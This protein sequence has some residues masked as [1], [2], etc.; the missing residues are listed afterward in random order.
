MGIDAPEV[1]GDEAGGDDGG[2]VGRDAISGED[3]CD[4][5]FGGRGGHVVLCL[6]GVGGIHSC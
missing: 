2:V 5:C 3:G 6:R 1:S 4:E